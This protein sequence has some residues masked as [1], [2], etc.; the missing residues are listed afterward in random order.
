MVASK[1]DWGLLELLE[2]FRTAYHLKQFTIK[3][4]ERSNTSIPANSMV[5]FLSG[6]IDCHPMLLVFHTH[7]LF[8]SQLS[9]YG[10]L[11]L[12]T[13]RFSTCRKTHISDQSTAV[14]PEILID[15]KTKICLDILSDFQWNS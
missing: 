2:K 4:L 7:N 14:S 5:H 12:F 15:L 6:Y 13:F 8:S 10:K 1:E 9:E 3:V 11:H